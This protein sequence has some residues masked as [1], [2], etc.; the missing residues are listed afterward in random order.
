MV[1][2]GRLLWWNKCSVL[3][4]RSA[5]LTVESLF[6]RGTVVRSGRFP[7]QWSTC[8]VG[9]KRG[10]LSR[11]RK[12]CLKDNVQFCFQ[13]G[14]FVLLELISTCSS[15]HKAPYWF[16]LWTEV[17]AEHRLDKSCI[18]SATLSIGL[19]TTE[20]PVVTLMGN[21]CACITWFPELS[22]QLNVKEL[23]STKHHKHEALTTIKMGDYISH[24]S[25]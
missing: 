23:Y 17:S 7:S 1:L 13:R 15:G 5:R 20:T 8:P 18:Y 24:V 21:S 19:I 12:K 25:N 9:N 2:S 6:T 22:W 3:H 10:S 16:W 4:S 11:N 14:H